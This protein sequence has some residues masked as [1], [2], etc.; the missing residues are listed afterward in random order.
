MTRKTII[1][2]SY[3]RFRHTLVIM[4]ADLQEHKNTQKSFLFNT[5]LQY[6]KLNKE[7]IIDAKPRLWL[8]TDITRIPLRYYIYLENNKD[9]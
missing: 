5:R 7:I 4:V 9:F 3:L 8:M 1:S 6:K 2:I